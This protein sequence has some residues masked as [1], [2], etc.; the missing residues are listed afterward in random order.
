MPLLVERSVVSQTTSEL[1]KDVTL[2]SLA[3]L[4]ALT[5]RELVVLVVETVQPPGTSARIVF[6]AFVALLVML[7]TVVLTIALS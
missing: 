7:L 2:T 4:S 5:F 3:M 1:L 6:T